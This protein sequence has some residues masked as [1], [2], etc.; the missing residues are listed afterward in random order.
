MRGVQPIVT[1]T[2]AYGLVGAG[3]RVRLRVPAVGRGAGRIPRGARGCV[4][5]E[6]R[7]VARRGP[8]AGAA[9][10]GGA[11]RPGG[12][13]PTPGPPPPPPLGP[14]RAAPARRPPP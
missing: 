4:A 6:R 7:G 9:R 3:I 13:A 14:P 12:V 8:A 5:R 1:R 2:F 10:A 11:P